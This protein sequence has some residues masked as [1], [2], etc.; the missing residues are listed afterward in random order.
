LRCTGIRP[1]DVGKHDVFIP[2]RG[3]IAAV[4]SAATATATP[5]FGRRLGERQGIDILGPVGVAARTAA[6]VAGVFR[7][8]ENF[9][10]AYSPAVS[11]VITPSADPEQ[12]FSNS[13]L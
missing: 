7:I 13:G 9:M 6:T 2:L 3:V 8:F 10:A 12:S 11:A 4:E 5:D 1:Q